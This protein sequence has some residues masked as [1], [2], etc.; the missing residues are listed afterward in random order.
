MLKK[1][2]AIALLILLADPL[3]VMAQSDGEPLRV[4]I[5]P[6]EPFVLLDGVEPS[7]FSIDLWDAIASQGDLSYEFVEV[8][9]VASLLEAVATG[10]ADLGIGATSITTQREET[11]DF[12]QPFF[13]SGL[14]ILT[15]QG[16]S[17][18]LLGALR[19][20]FTGNLIRF[21]AATFAILL[22]IAH[23]AY[24]LERDENSD[25]QGGY[26]H[27]IYNAFYWTIVTASTV[28]YGDTVLKD[29]RGKFLAMVWILMGI[30]LV[31]YFTATVTASLTLGQLEQGIQSP[32]D[33]RGRAVVTL[34]GTTS[35][36]FL[37]SRGIVFT[38]AASIPEAI[39]LLQNGTVDAIVYDAP[40]LQYYSTLAIGR[41][42]V[43]IPNRFQTENYGIV[44]PQQSPVQESVNRALL[45]LYEN[46]VHEQI[47]LRWF[48]EQE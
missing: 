7:G 6:V 29:T 31:S 23:V 45:T 8:D 28:G 17:A 18:G 46:G 24:F 13:A 3:L 37:Q 2:L 36:E 43:L 30:F 22:I 4:A 20:I 39:G 1:L 21:L 9:S 14:Q 38:T 34:A 26:L 48:G 44:F 11:F 42:T 15:R 5:N 35:A 40:V 16:Q 19:S 41:D 27:G 10:R 25:F 47:R 32:G 12:S 33:L